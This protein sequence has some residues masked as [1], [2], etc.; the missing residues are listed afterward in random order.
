MGVRFEGASGVG[1]GVY[2]IKHLY[3]LLNAGWR[4]YR[5][6]DM[7]V[8][9]KCIRRLPLLHKRAQNI[10]EASTIDTYMPPNPMDLLLEAPILWISEPYRSLERN[11]FNLEHFQVGSYRYRSLTEGL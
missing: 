7:T 2:I 10:A 3:Y 1:F 4:I 9:S 8:K 5:G 6:L 11:R